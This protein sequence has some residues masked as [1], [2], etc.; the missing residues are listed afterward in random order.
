[1]AFGLFQ[2][3]EITATQLRALPEKGHPRE[4]FLAHEAFHHSI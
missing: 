1:M 4:G 3:R 2:N